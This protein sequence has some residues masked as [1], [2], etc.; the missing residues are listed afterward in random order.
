MSWASLCPLFQWI[1]NT[2][3]S[4]AIRNSYILRPLIEI[5]HLLGISLALGTILFVDFSL[6][7]KAFRPE[8][9]PRIARQLAPLTRAGF[10]FVFAT[11]A[12]LFWSDAERLHDK[13]MFWAK[14][15][16]LV[17][18][19]AYHCTIRRKVISSEPFTPSRGGRIAAG[20]SLLLW[21]GIAFMGKG[22]G[23]V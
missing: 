20:A 4:L 15:G 18:A 8:A 22:I 6:L 14:M 1:D 16:V 12:I 19:L 17:V 2:A 5:L 7:G 9:V 21:V 23:L 3:L 11:G 10:S 13:P